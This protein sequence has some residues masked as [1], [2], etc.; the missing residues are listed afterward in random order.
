MAYEGGDRSIERRE[1]VRAAVEGTVVM[2]ADETSDYVMHSVTNISTGG[3][4]I[5]TPEVRPVGTRLGVRLII[6]GSESVIEGTAEV[7]WVRTIDQFQE[8]PPGMAVRFVDMDQATRLQIALL[9]QERAE[10]GTTVASLSEP[11]MP[12]GVAEEPFGMEGGDPEERG[13]A[14][15]AFDVFPAPSDDEEATA[16]NVP[17][18]ILGDG[19]AYELSG[20]A[21]HR[22]FPGPGLIVLV[23]AVAVVAIGIVGYLA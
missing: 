20:D 8:G 3:M 13:K 17:D 10:K 5:R 11:P 23:V 4:F 7:V 15:P 18:I 19:K 1:T 9:V 21:P 16:S 22:S 6:A 12:L 14:I 2:R